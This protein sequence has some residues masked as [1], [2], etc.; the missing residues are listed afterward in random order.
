M[1]DDERIQELKE[2]ITKLVD[3]EFSGDWYRAFNHYAA[4][5]GSPALVDRK[6]LL[7]LLDA[8]DVGNM[9]TRG[10]WA[11]GIIEELDTDVDGSIS[12]SEFEAVFQRDG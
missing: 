4:L 3:S 11:D 12:W 7:E 6:D 9:F 8:A 5:H 1:A 10:A 2:K